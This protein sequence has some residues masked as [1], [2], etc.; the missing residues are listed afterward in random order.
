MPR[1]CFVERIRGGFVKCVSFGENRAVLCFIL[2]DGEKNYNRFCAK[3]GMHFLVLWKTGRGVL[4]GRV[5]FAG[6]TGNV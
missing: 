1:G 4:K 5:L 2:H 3:H 6:K